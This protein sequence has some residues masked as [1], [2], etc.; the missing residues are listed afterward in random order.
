MRLVAGLFGHYCGGCAIALPVGRDRLWCP[1]CQVS[2]LP[3]TTL[4]STD[5]GLPVVAL[6]LFTGPV[7]TW[8]SR[9]KAGE[10][11]PALAPVQLQWQACAARVVLRDVAR[12][13]PVPPQ[14]DRLR[15]RGWHL[16]DLLA[17]EL[18]WPIDRQ[19]VRRDTAAPRREQRGAV[20]TFAF[21]GQIQRPVVLVD[22]VITTGA[23]LDTAAAVLRAAGVTVLGAACLADAR[24]E[25]IALAAA[26]LD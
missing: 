23:T 10:R 1:A 13:V 11:A 3:C 12:V 16:P 7:A 8:I 19:L 18:G 14:L 24:P 22:D 6:W 15:A 17:D 5:G 26:Q 4:R 21:R 25:S 9:S 2:V 20:P